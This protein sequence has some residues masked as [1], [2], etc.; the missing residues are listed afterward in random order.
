MN[1]IDLKEQIMLLR[2]GDR[3]AFECIYRELS[4]PVYTL[5]LRM[6]ND[7]MLAED[8]L[9]EFFI[10]LFHSPPQKSVH[11]PRAYLFRSVRN[12]AIDALR[13]C[14]KT[15]E[16]D[17]SV[18]MAEEDLAERIDIETAMERLSRE[19]RQIV[20]LHIDGSLRFREVAEIMG[21]PLGTILWRYHRA[22]GLMRELLN[23]GAE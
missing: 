9:Q 13:K 12:L 17:E 3:E 15:E 7:R 2:D 19:D 16:I 20:S 11:K 6:T 18:C 23:G 4:A 10:K 1:D 21:M 14:R 8:I 22:L 5:L